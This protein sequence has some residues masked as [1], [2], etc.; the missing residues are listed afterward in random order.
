MSAVGYS[1]LKLN[2]VEFL[3]SFGRKLKT[4]HFVLNKNCI[5][6]YQQNEKSS[7]ITFDS[8]YQSCFF[9]HFSFDF[10]FINFLAGL[11]T[12]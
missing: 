2:L 6:F 5:S 1:Q 3:T 9:G 4:R 12:S 8:L 10:K 11:T 7:F